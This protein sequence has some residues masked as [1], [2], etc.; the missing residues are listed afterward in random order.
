MKDSGES[1]KSTSSRDQQGGQHSESEP[2]L[3]SSEEY[4]EPVW[5]QYT[6]TFVGKFSINI[7]IKL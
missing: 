6:A 7:E 5:R 1:S 2:L 3:K 4:R